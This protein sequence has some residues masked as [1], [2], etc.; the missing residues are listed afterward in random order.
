MP[1]TA[2]CLAERDGLSVSGKARVE[3][4]QRGVDAY[5]HMGFTKLDPYSPINSTSNPGGIPIDGAFSEP[6][7]Q[8]PM[9]LAQG[10]LYVTASIWG[11][12][13]EGVGKQATVSDTSNAAGE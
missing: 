6:F 9:N 13:T 8:P 2:T 7:R 4:N 1:Y 11:V 10:K 5:Y 12:N 3:A